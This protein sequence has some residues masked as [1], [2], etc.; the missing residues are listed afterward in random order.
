MCA[1]CWQSPWHHGTSWPLASK[2]DQ[3]GRSVLQRNLAAHVSEPF[4]TVRNRSERKV[5]WNLRVASRDQQ[6]RMLIK[7]LYCFWKVCWVLF[8]PY[9]RTSK[10]SR[11]YKKPRAAHTWSKVWSV[12][13][14]TALRE[15]KHKW[16]DGGDAVFVR[17]LLS[18][19]RSSGQS[20]L[21]A[22]SRGQ[23]WFTRSI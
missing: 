7:Y 12:L 17:L 22:K 16:S 21:V 15:Q 2:G 11:L 19:W 6:P 18:C 23:W 10:A 8:F 9:A 1:M 3:P 4:W 14:I 20:N 13:T 5:L